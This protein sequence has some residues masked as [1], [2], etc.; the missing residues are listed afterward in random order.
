MKTIIRVSKKEYYD[1]MFRNFIIP[2]DNKAKLFYCYC[3]Y[4]K[5]HRHYH[6]RMHFLRI[7]V[8]NGKPLYRKRK[9]L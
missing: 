3:C 6:A 4:Y 8:N 5:S 9:Y 2:F 1:Y 7:H